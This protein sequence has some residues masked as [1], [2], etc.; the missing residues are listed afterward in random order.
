MAAKCDICGGKTGFLRTFHCRDGVVC[1]N[2]YKI[3]SGNYANTIADLTLMEL[4]KIYIKNARP[5]DMGEGGF[6]TTR[7]IGSF[8]LL[9]ETN[10]KF[11]ILNNQKMTGQNTRPEIFPCQEL[12]RAGI[13][14]SPDLSEE[15]LSSL[16]AE[17][18]SAVIIRKLSVRLELKSAG[19]REIA[20]IPTPVRA[21][22]FAFR[23]GH[24]M[25]EEILE[26]LR[27]I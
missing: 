5:L 16:A 3:V 17:K 26:C 7:K 13:S 20:I 11:C 2:C 9:D 21:S 25:A 14:A 18:D 6:K 22:S 8:L 19:V 4:K 12:K 24:K 10:R 15:Q 1:K 27:S 23:Q